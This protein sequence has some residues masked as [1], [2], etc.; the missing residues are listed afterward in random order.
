MPKDKPA[1]ETTNLAEQ[2]ALAGIQGKKEILWPLE[3]G[4]GNSGC[5]QG[6]QEVM[7]GEN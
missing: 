7:Q 4:A 5:M 6:Y 1:E 3:V 2:R